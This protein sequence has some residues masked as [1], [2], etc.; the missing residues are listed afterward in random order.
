[1]FRPSVFSIIILCFFTAL[2]NN[3]KAQVNDSDFLKGVILCKYYDSLSYKLDTTSITQIGLTT[4]LHKYKAAKVTAPFSGLNASLDRVYKV[5]IGR[6]GGIDTCIAALKLLPYIQYVERYPVFK[7]S[8]DPNDYIAANQYSLVKINASLAWGITKGSTKVVV[9]IVDNGVRTTHED[10]AANMWVNSAEI[11]NNGFDDDLNGYADDV[12]GYDISDRDGNPNPPAGVA[13]TSGW[14]HGTHCAGI[15]SAVT[16]NGKGIASI[17]YNLKI[18]AVKCVADKGNPDVITDAL[19][20]VSYAEKAGANIISMSF[21]TTQNSQ[22]MQGLVNQANSTGIL[23]VAAAG[24]SNNETV[25]YPAGYPTVLSVAATDPNDAKASFSNYGT[26]VS[27]SAP[28]VSIKS[29]FPSSN[30]AY[31]LLSGT[32]MAT[33]MVAGLA[34]LVLSV[35]PTFKP[36]QVISAIKK[37]CDNID[38]LNS[39][40]A[41]KLGAGRINAAKTFGISSVAQSPGFAHYCLLYPNPVAHGDEVYMESEG[42]NISQLNIMDLSGR[43]VKT[44]MTNGNIKASSLGITTE[45]MKP[46]IYMIRANY[47]GGSDIQKLIIQ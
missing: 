15:C 31:G 34:G 39:K 4:I 35:N 21:G 3:C 18:M 46:G 5:T 38:G 41:G 24:N 37:G 47:A 27:L 22:T 6:P 13:D 2:A 7:A 44:I 11:A 33:P 25:L 36:A 32:S 8:G 12:N 45:G 14:V 43:I 19:E 10:L 26:W 16:N 20:G 40:Y 9:A 23:M 17:G 29:T 1:M 42:N 30:S 28:G